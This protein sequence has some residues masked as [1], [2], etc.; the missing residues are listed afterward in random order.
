MNQSL[1]GRLFDKACGYALGHVLVAL[2]ALDSKL[3][4]KRKEWGL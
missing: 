2:F 1:F 4:Q 3:A